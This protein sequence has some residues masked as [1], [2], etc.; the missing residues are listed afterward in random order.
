MLAALK[1][2]DWSQN[3]RPGVEASGYIT[4]K[5]VGWGARPHALGCAPA[6]ARTGA[7]DAPAPK[8]SAAVEHARGVRDCPLCGHRIYT[9]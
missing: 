6:D 8:A 5:E 7:R 4:L 2:V 3:T 1:L 9:P